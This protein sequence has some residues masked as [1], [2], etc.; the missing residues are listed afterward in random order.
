MV[1][2][3][4]V[5]LF[6]PSPWQLLITLWLSECLCYDYEQPF[7][8]CITSNYTAHHRTKWERLS[9]YCCWLYR[10]C[11]TTYQLLEQLLAMLDQ[12]GVL[13][14]CRDC[15]KI[16]CFFKLSKAC[17]I[18]TIMFLFLYMCHWQN[19]AHSSIEQK[20]F[21][22]LKKA[23]KINSWSNI[24]GPL[25]AHFVDLNYYHNKLKPY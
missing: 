15:A 4:F 21:F 23:S 18:C 6:L 7:M 20:C 5:I 17:L 3:T 19:I 22:F 11:Y 10:L 1:Q 25:T 8:T 9:V 13:A 12:S 2:L 14:K 16:L 24:K